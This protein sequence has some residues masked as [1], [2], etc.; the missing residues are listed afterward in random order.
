M[1]VSPY[2][3]NVPD[4]GKNYTSPGTGALFTPVNIATGTLSAAQDFAIAQSLKLGNSLTNPNTFVAAAGASVAKGFAPP[5]AAA[6]ATSSS[7]SGQL[8]GNNN[9]VWTFIVAPEDISWDTAVAVNRVD[10]FGTNH[11]PVIVGTKGMRDLSLTNALVEGFTRARTVEGRI[12]ALEKLMRFTLNTQGGFVNV[13]VYNVFANTKKYG[14][15][16]SSEGGYFVI[17]DIKIKE[18]MRDFDGLATRAYADI[19]LVQVPAYQVEMGI[20][21]ASAPVSGATS[22]LAKMEP[23]LTQPQQPASTRS[24]SSGPAPAPAP[25]RQPSAGGGTGGARP[26]S[27]GSQGNNTPPTA[28]PTLPGQRINYR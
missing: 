23:T 4:F 9:D 18:T 13:P 19:S 14:G 27:S 12:L 15:V 24:G 16:D 26:G 5:V 10:I 11:P 6:S 3:A 2:G 20:D 8:G 25:R 1:A 17:K 7:S 21:Q 22:L 28:T